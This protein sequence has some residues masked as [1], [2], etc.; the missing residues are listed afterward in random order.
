MPIAPRP[1]QIQQLVERA[2]DGAIYM[3][4]LLKFKERAEY[5]G[6]RDTNLTGQEA[7]GLYGA[8]VGK[9]IAALGGNIIWGGV[10][11]TLVVGDGDLAWDQV[12][13]VAYPSLQSFQDMTASEAYQEVHVHREAGLAHQLL[14]NCL[15]PEQVMAAMG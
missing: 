12:A 13:I 8:G 14:I 5:P 3:L 10:T 15:S 2:P 1:E 9:L 6:G 4:N 11:N 7:Y